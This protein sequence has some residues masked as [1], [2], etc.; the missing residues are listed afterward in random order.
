MAAVE[1]GA[2][3]FITGTDTGVGKTVFAAGLALYLRR[4][5]LST[6]V[7]KPAESGVDD[8]TR[9]GPDA[10]AL[11][12]AADVDDP[13][14]VISPYRLKEPLAPS[15]AARQEGV[16]IAPATIKECFNILKKKYDFIIVEGAGGLMVPLAGGILFADLA[17]DMAL[18]LL[19]VTRPDLG[20]INHTFLT[21]FAAQ[22][23]QLP[24]SGYLINRMPAHPDIACRTAPHTMS[25]LLPG[26]LLGVVPDLGNDDDYPALIDRAANQ[27]ESLP[28]LPLLLT[29]LGLK[30]LI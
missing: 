7:M 21:L 4:R 29:S 16:R 11:K 23:M 12:W 26:D 19:V 27:I 8:P 10:E 15:V 28:T 3:V 24:L 30:G 2:G 18:P 14:D 9:L 6:G 5:G 17:R 13:D 20:T 25:S 22:Q 1:I